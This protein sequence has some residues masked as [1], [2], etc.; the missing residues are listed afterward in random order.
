MRR[1]KPRK[2]KRWV[3]E[4]KQEAT[5]PDSGVYELSNG[6]VSTHSSWKDCCTAGRAPPS[7]AEKR[8]WIENGHTVQRGLQTKCIEM[9]CAIEN[10]GSRKLKG[11]HERAPNGAEKEK[12]GRSYTSGRC[13][14]DGRAKET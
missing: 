5:R 13:L 9:L 6:R 3:H 14:G 10:R 4:F 7:L 11:E 1:R 12:R 8:D 2:K